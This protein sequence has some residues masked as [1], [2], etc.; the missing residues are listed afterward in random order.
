[1][2]KGLISAALIL[3]M[4]VSAF[5]FSAFAESSTVI[6]RI[7]SRYALNGKTVYSLTDTEYSALKDRIGDYIQKCLA[8][9]PGRYTHFES[10]SANDDFTVFS[11][12]LNST[13]L[14]QKEPDA[15]NIVFDLG[16]MYDAYNCKSVKNIR[17]DYYDS[18]GEL[19]YSSN[20]EDK[21][22]DWI[23]YEEPGSFR[24][25][26]AAADHVAYAS[27]SA[28]ASAV[29][30]SRKSNV[31]LHVDAAYSIDGETDYSLTATE[32]ENLLTRVRDYITGEL[33]KCTR[34]AGEEYYHFDSITA[35]KDFT[36]YVITVNDALNLTVEERTIKDK[37]LHYTEM[38]ALYSRQKLGIIYVYYKTQKGEYLR[39]A[40]LKSSIDAL[41]RPDPP[42]P[43]RSYS[44]VATPP[45]TGYLSSLS[46]H[47]RSALAPDTT[48]TYA[49]QQGK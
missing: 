40:T 32:Y 9:L 36:S 3:L 1:M 23:F 21:Q 48:Q 19:L 8:R 26:E 7:P 37:L 43:E 17:I 46:E 35:D 6:L 39:T 42:K 16:F 13:E 27:S 31:V 34:S 22:G 30:Q 47:A 4:L 2:R 49:A 25:N 38:Y 14:D 11:I 10:V 5:P 41:A 29:Q 44:Y 18:Q 12:V 33:N 20:S 24:E 28:S 45:I 15:E